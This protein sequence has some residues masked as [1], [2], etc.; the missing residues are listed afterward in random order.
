MAPVVAVATTM[1]TT[2]TTIMIMVMIVITMLMIAMTTTVIARP[3]MRAMVAL[4]PALNPPP[5]HPM[6]HRW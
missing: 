4:T 2:I 5:G 1:G 3:T 6:V